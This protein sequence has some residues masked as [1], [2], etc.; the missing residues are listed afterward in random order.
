MLISCESGSDDNH[1]TEM[2]NKN[3]T[4]PFFGDSEK[5]VSF[6][7]SGLPMEASGFYMFGFLAGPNPLTNS[8]IFVLSGQPG[9]RCRV[10]V[11]FFNLTIDIR[12]TVYTD[13]TSKK[14]C[15]FWVGDTSRHC[16]ITYPPPKYLFRCQTIFPDHSLFAVVGSQAALSQS[17]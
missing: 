16:G 14:A 15:I 17:R 6:S 9:G 11:A 1:I 2:N 3:Q 8:L 4:L 5:Q 7:E 10:V 12:F 13:K